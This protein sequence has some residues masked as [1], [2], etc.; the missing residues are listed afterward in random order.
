MTQLLPGQLL[1]IFGASILDAA[2]LS[3]LALLWYR[4]S[5]NR[6]MREAQPDAVAGS[7]EQHNSPV[8]SQ[9]AVP[10]TEPGELILAEERPETLPHTAAIPRPGMVRLIV[11]YSVGAAAFA[12]VITC[13]KFWTASPPLPAVAWLVDWWT[14]LWPVVPT[15]VALLVLD[16]PIARAPRASLCARRRNRHLPVHR[17]RTASQRH[18]QQRAA[19]E[20]LL[21]RRQPRMDRIIPVRGHRLDRLAARAR[22]DAARPG[23][24]AA[25]RLRL[26]AVPRAARSR[27]ERRG[28]QVRVSQRRRVLVTHDDAVCPVHAREPSSRLARMAAP[29]RAGGRIREQAIQRHPAGRRLLV[30]GCRCRS[31]GDLAVDDAWCSLELPAASPPFSLIDLPWLRCFAAIVRRSGPHVC[32]CFGCS[33]IRRAPNRCSI[34]WRRHGGSRVPSSSSR[35]SIWRCAPPI[36]AICSRCSMA[37][38]PRPT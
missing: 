26:G 8:P 21:G 16:R 29:E 37:G 24:H 23:R 38:W 15:L 19:D 25:V 1:Y 35:A 12:A 14:N 30:G 2:L 31:D 17:G 4:R 20:Y 18:A 3:W 13:F 10:P 5:V 6:L 9:S 34:A 11:A 27:V 28:V 33:V 32:C 7:A 22:G 36:P